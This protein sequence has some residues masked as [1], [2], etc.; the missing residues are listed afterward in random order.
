MVA[1]FIIDR[2]IAIQASWIAGPAFGVAMMAAPDYLKLEAPYS[3]LL[4]W[5]GIGVFL[6]TVAVVVMLSLHE[7]KNRKMVLGPIIMMGFGALILCGGAAWYFWPQYRGTTT[8]QADENY[9]Q[10]LGLEGAPL[11]WTPGIVIIYGKD[12]GYISKFGFWAINMGDKEVSL[13][14]VYV[15][16]ALTGKR[17]DLMAYTQQPNIRRLRVN[18]I[19]PIPP[20]ATITLDSGMLDGKDGVSQNEFLATWG[21]MF[22][23]VEYSNGEMYRKRIDQA[24]IVDSIA[25]SLQMPH[26][27]PR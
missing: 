13:D 11:G 2:H 27:S 4:F 9:A 19:N 16:S 14:N 21:N 20:N 25:K 18:E 8:P 7:E 22:F 12:H 6:F 5:G 10:A 15:I 3:G 17:I 1:M 26:V 24:L 23:V